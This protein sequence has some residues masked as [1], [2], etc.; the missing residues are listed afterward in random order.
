MQPIQAT[1]ELGKNMGDGGVGR[2][3]EGISAFSIMSK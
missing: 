1:Q 3:Y 2:H